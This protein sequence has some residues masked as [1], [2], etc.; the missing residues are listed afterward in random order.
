MGKG[1]IK[2]LVLNYLVKEEIFP[3]E[4]LEYVALSGEHTLV[5]RKL[6]YQET[7]KALQLKLKELDMREK[8]L[9]LEYKAKELELH[10]AKT[11]TVEVSK[12][13]FDIR[14]HIRFVPPFQESEK[15]KY[16]MHFE[17]VATSLKWPED[18]WTV[19]LRSVFVGKARE[20]YSALSV[21]HSA[22]YQTVRD[23]VLMAYEVRHIDEI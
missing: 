11:R 5:L 14:K 1:D 20:I 21:E 16:F 3:E 17:K 19:L 10:N 12:V 23:A 8:E 9:A 22:R 2:K 7:D 15:D 18:V 13:P 6:D 4:D